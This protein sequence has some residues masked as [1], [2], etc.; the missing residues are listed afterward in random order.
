MHHE[1]DI[2]L[3]QAKKFGLCRIEDLDDLLRLQKMVT[4][5]KA[6]QRSTRLLSLLTL[7]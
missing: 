3:S 4:G 7:T 6:A 1:D 5:A 2:T